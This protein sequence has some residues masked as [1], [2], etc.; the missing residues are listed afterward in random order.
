MIHCYTCSYIYKYA[1][2]INHLFN[3]LQYRSFTAFSILSIGCGPGSDF[4]G[5]INF[6]TQQNRTMPLTYLGI[7]LNPLWESTHQTIRELF[8]DLPISFSTTDVFDFLDDMEDEQN[9]TYN[10]VIL[11]YVLNEINKY[12]PDRIQ[13]FI[14]KLAIFLVDRMPINSTV[15]LNDFN[16]YITRNLF[17]R[18]YA[19][20]NVH[21]LVSYSEYRFTNP[22]SHTLGGHVHPSDAL[23]FTVP[24]EIRRLH[25]IKSPCSSAQVVIYK[26]RNR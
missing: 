17:S 23:L 2:E 18:V 26:T 8:P 4:F 9:S 11:Q 6:L 25:E 1:S 13:E 22:I 16:H 19:A 14:D 10:I 24:D 21:N 15:I 7:D 20:I 3:L 5:I 12:T